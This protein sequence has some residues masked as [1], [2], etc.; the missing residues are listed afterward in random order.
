MWFTAADL[1][2]TWDLNQLADRLMKLQIED[3]P[4]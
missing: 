2:R 1:A 3:R 4:A